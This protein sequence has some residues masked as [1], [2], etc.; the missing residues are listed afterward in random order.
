MDSCNGSL[1]T[2]RVSAIQN[3][4]DPLL[5]CFSH[6]RWNFVYQRPQHLLSRAARRYQVIFFEEP[7]I[8]ADAPPSGQLCLSNPQP[9]VTVAVP[10]LPPGLRAG[11]ET[12]LQR[13]LLSQLMNRVGRRGR[14]L[15]AW[16]YTPMA[17]RFSD[18]LVPDLVVY[19]CMDELSAFKNAPPRLSR[20]EHQLFDLA[21]VVFTGGQ[22]LFEAKQ[23][24]H[25]NVHAFPSSIDAHHFG[26][27]RS[28]ELAD[29]ADQKSIGRPRIGFFGVVDERMDIDLVAGLA[30]HRPDWQFIVLGPVVKIDPASLP[31]RANLHWLGGKAY[32]ELPAYLAHWDAG[33]MPFALNDATRFISP[34]KTPEFLAAG[35]PVVST[36]IRD[37]VRPYGEDRL[38][39]IAADVSGFAAA[40]ERALAA[41]CETWRAAVDK[42]LGG[43]SWDRTWARMSARMDDVRQRQGRTGTSTKTAPARG[44]VTQ[45]EVAGV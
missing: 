3:G 44:S 40:L 45:R 12:R 41:D 22:S 4:G 10:T 24:Q 21:D 13:S 37:V 27:A 1:P 16:Y 34:T 14:E 9:G 18:H 32:G 28:G 25:A 19:D 5:V 15:V 30:D 38:V 39:G 8:S 7:E 17:L 35:V 2:D 31:R 29:P 11:H 20:L 26:R 33:F 6:L 36:P 43:M 23:R 42:R